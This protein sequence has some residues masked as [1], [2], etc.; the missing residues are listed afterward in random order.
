MGS[1]F[2]FLFFWGY[3]SSFL[4]LLSQP[5]GGEPQKMGSL[6]LVPFVNPFIGTG[7]HGHT[8]PGA[9]CPF[10]MV[11]LSPDTRNDAS[12]DACGG[13]YYHDSFIYGFSHTHLSGTGVSDLGDILFQPLVAPEFE[14]EAYKQRF[15]H[16]Q[17]HAEAG[18]Y[19]VKFPESQIQVELTATEYTGLQRVV[20]PPKEGLKWIL[21]DLKHRDALWSFSLRIDGDYRVIG[22]RQSKQWADNQWVFFGSSFNQTIAAFR[23]NA[24]STKLLLGFEYETLLVQTTLS[25]TSHEGVLVN[26][27]ATE[28]RFYLGDKNGFIPSPR[29]LVIP[30]ET[31]KQYVQRCWEAD[32]GR[33]RVLRASP[34]KSLTQAFQSTHALTTFYTALYHAMIHPSLA[35]DADGNYRGRDQQIHQADHVTYHVFSLWD[36]YRG[37]HPLLTLIDKNRTRDFILTMLAQSEQGGLLPVWELGSCETQCMIGFHSVPVILDAVRQG[38]YFSDEEIQRLW[39]AVQRSSENKEKEFQYQIPIQRELLTLYGL[40]LGYIDVLKESESVSKTLEYAYDDYCVSELATLWGF[41]T[42]GKTFKERSERWKGLWDTE[43]KSFRP[44]QNGQFLEPFYLNEV[45]NHYTEATAWQYRFAVPHDMEQLIRYFGGADSFERALDSLFGTSSVTRGREQADI[46]GLIG[47]YAHGNE[48]SHHMAYL[49]NYVGKPEKA[50][51]VI[52]QI[53]SEFYTEGPE[54]YIGNEDCGQMSAWHVLSALGLYPVAPGSGYWDLGVP[55]FDSVRIF[56]SDADP[57]LIT[58]SVDTSERLWQPQ[59]L[60]TGHLR[61]FIGIHKTQRTFWKLSEQRAKAV[62]QERFGELI[63]NYSERI[64]RN[65]RMSHDFLM[66]HRALHFEK[67]DSLV[68]VLPSLNEPVPDLKRHI[69]ELISPSK[70]QRN[71]SY[72]VLVKGARSNA[73]VWVFIRFMD[74]PLSFDRAHEDFYRSFKVLQT[75][76][77]PLRMPGYGAHH[78]LIRVSNDTAFQL[79]GSALVWAAF[80]DADSWSDKPFV[81]RYIHEKPN[82]YNVLEIKGHYNPQYSGGGDGALI[83]GVLGSEEWRSGFWQGYQAQDFEAVIDLK[84]V[85]SIRYLGARFLSDERSWI[86]LPKDLSFEYSLDGITFKPFHTLHFKSESRE[87]A[88]IV[89][90]ICGFQSPKRWFRKRIDRV[91]ARFIRVKAKNYGKLPKGHPGYEASGDA[92]I[93]IDEILINPE[94]MELL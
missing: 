63:P 14:P 30:F 38:V 25:F 21:I 52:Q 86:F 41:D 75:Q 74:I 13:Y 50:Q 46:S 67:S 58:R 29:S 35:S 42:V 80:L 68:R 4:N 92:F 89:P 72:T 71:E 78:R 19:R 60:G 55:L 76:E 93:F 49:Y 94:V 9:V 54:G 85:H 79:A 12:W 34:S 62:Y 81:A 64:P 36:T 53:Q 45:N 87:H 65:H 33:I 43:S 39:K 88:Q 70:V 15:S 69:P 11:Q 28:N 90:L 84:E 22:H 1:T 2:R 32:L 66:I 16:E 47:Q 48:P 61:E 3:L 26:E 44:R 27:K 10:G 73:P 31:M 23:Y 8:F 91:D 59:N 51:S 77:G 83:D 37:L 6:T 40:K 7:G 5:V 56:Q 57:I 82:D 20:F 17:E 18:Y 24:D